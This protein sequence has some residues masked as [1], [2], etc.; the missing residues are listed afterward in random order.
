MNSF[1]KKNAIANQNRLKQFKN[2]V[3]IPISDTTKVAASLQ[4]KLSSID[5]Q[6]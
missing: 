1:F 2:K 3:E 5:L 4:T 6:L